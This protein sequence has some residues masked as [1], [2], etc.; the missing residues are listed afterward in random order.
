MRN[1]RVKAHP[2]GS[3]NPLVAQQTPGCR[4]RCLAGKG[5]GRAKSQRAWNAM[6]MKLI[7][8]AMASSLAGDAYALNPVTMIACTGPRPTGVNGKPS[9][10]TTAG[11]T[12]K[13]W[14]G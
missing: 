4:V 2:S 6:V 1:R 8:R 11:R 3:G 9:K 10:N 7:E 14:D 12:A 13:T 5:P